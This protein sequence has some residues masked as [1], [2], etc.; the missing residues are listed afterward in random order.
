MWS[1]LGG[2]KFFN[3]ATGFTD[4]VISKLVSLT[5]DHDNGSTNNAT[6]PCRTTV[7]TTADDEYVSSYL[8]ILCFIRLIYCFIYKYSLKR[9]CLFHSSIVH[10]QHQHILYQHLCHHDI[11]PSKCN[12]NMIQQWQWQSEHHSSSNYNPNAIWQWK[13]QWQS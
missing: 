1:R 9:V 13:R 3:L 6:A 11:L 12:R 7:S 10:Y 4:M 2:C 8:P 5:S